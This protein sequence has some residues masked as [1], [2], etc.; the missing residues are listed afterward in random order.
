M[1]EDDT[2]DVLTTLLAHLVEYDS[3]GVWGSDFNTCRVCG[4]GGSPYMPF[5]HE[6]DCPVVS[7]EEY[8][9]AYV[10]AAIA[11]ATASEGTHE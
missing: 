6:K 8:V 2:F 5:K 11:R 9:T 10:E 3:F 1:S 4:G 7:A